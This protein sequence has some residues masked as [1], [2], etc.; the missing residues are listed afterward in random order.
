MAKKPKKMI[1]N[2]KT[3]MKHTQTLLNVMIFLYFVS[4]KVTEIVTDRVFGLTL[5]ILSG[6]SIPILQKINSQK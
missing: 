6:E 2:L 3:V 1:L 4:L 5:Y